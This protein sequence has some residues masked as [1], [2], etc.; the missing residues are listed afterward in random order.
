MARPPEAVAA[1]DSANLACTSAFS[2][3]CVF[4]GSKTGNRSSFVEAAE[5]LGEELVRRGV[6]LVY[7][8]GGVGLMGKVSGTV[9]RKG[10]KVLG[11]IPVA[12]Q[13]VELSGESVGEVRVVAD[14]H[15][16]KALMAK[17]ADAFIAL[18]GGFGTLE[19]L[20]EVIT[21]QQLGYHTK[22]IGC[23]NIDGYF[24]LLLAFIDKSVQSG[25]ITQEARE[26]RNGFYSECAHRCYGGSSAKVS[27]I[28]TVLW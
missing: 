5:L 6:G 2:S 7:G 23:L 18:P 22:P 17:E 14:M 28:V 12:L 9:F 3:V 21:W 8:G 27:R 26:I 4:C 11:V 16:R 24:D 13:P 10:G 15:E 19:E 20:L 1:A 25:F